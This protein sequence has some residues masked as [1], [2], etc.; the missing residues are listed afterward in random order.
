MEDKDKIIE[1]NVEDNSSSEPNNQDNNES[2]SSSSDETTSSVSKV[3]KTDDL[4]QEVISDES[5][6]GASTTSEDKVEKSDDSKESSNSVETKTEQVISDKDE[7]EQSEDSQKDEDPVEDQSEELKESD[8]SKRNFIFP[9]LIG[10]KIGMSQ[11]FSEDGKCT[12]TT[13]LEVGPCL[14]T[15]IKNNDSD[16]Y[17]AVQIGYGNLNDK[18][19]NKAESGHFTKNNLSVKKHLK[20]FRVNNIKDDYKIGDEVTIN[21]FE[22]G[23][24]VNITG[25]SKGKGFTGHMKRHG[26][27][28]GR[29]SH[30]KNS[31]MRKAGSVG[32]GSDPSR[33]FP[34]MKMAG[35]KGNFKVTIKNLP[36]MSIDE[37]NNLIYLKGSIPGAANS[38]IYLSKVNM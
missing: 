6:S 22:V 2:V 30:G 9:Y 38:L 21:Q 27:G 5:Q 19:A 16:G 18:K 4:N 31:V 34:G 37:N 29:R 32:A 3:D 13:V 36:V 7:I 35:R 17:N 24:Q 25:Y 33:V 11:V 8:S 10:K 12:P 23:D 15:Q 26:F 28:G 20:E 14:I 1:N